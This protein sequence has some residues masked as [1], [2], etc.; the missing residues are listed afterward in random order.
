MS[1]L[2]IKQAD[3]CDIKQADNP[4]SKHDARFGYSLKID[5][6][7]RDTNPYTYS[8]SGGK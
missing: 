5:F 6:P 3:D 1:R 7:T 8:N 2:N 4:W